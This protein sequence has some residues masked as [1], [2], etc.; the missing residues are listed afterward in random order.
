[1]LPASQVRKK[2]TQA[3]KASRALVTEANKVA[4]ALLMQDID[5]FLEDNARNIEELAA[6]HSVKPEYVK[7]LV[8]PKTTYKK[9]RAPTLPNAIAHIKAVEI[10]EGEIHIIDVLGNMTYSKN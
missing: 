7:K 8:N 2:L 5:V 1:M 3:E 9:Q 4:R 6:K 10:N